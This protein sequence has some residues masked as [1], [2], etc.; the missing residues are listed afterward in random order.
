MAVSSLWTFPQSRGSFENSCENF[1]VE[2]SIQL[3]FSG[4]ALFHS[5][6]KIEGSAD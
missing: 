1:S 6:N 3:F 2:K 5:Q 4:L